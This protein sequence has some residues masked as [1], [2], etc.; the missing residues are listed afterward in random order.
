MAVARRVFVV[1]FLFL[2][3]FVL[4][5]VCCLWFVDCVVV[6]VLFER[7]GGECRVSIFVG[8]SPRSGSWFQWWQLGLSKAGTLC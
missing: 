5:S 6:G 3:L 1:V 4:V 2:F 7:S 8:R